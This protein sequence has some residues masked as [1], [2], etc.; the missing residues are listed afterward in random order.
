[1]KYIKTFEAYSGGEF[2]DAGEPMMT[3]SQYRDYSEPSEPDYDDEQDNDINKNYYNDLTNPDRKFERTYDYIK[4]NN[5]LIDGKPESETWYDNVKIISRFA[6]YSKNTLKYFFKEFEYD[7]LSKNNLIPNFFYDLDDEIYL[8][9]M[10]STDTNTINGEKTITWQGEEYK[11]N[12]RNDNY[13]FDLNDKV[14]EVLRDIE[15]EINEMIDPSNL[16]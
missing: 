14:N 1:M 2:N 13:A 3:H 12:F 15:S 5:I 16:F 8:D 7:T 4:R 6:G 11:L 9:G 10:F